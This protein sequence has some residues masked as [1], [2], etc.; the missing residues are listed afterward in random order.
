MGGIVSA[1]MWVFGEV[2]GGIL[3]FAEWASITLFHPRVWNLPEGKGLFWKYLY[4]CMKIGFYLLCFTLGGVGITFLG[5]LYVYTKLYKKVSTPQNEDESSRKAYDEDY[6]K[7]GA[8]D[9]EMT[10]QDLEIAQQKEQTD[11]QIF[12]L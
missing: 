11:Q 4:W 8:N 2:V 3:S 5:I 6:K 12:A 10:I 1:V 7:Y 9:D